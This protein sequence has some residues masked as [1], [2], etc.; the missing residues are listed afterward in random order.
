MGL[1]SD[2][3]NQFV[4]D[5]NGDVYF[6]NSAD[7]VNATQGF[8][9]IRS[10]LTFMNSGD[11]RYIGSNDFLPG[12]DNQV[13]GNRGK[14][15]LEGSFKNPTRDLLRGGKDDDLIFGGIGGQDWI[16]GANDNDT[17]VG[18]TNDSSILRGGKGDDGITGGNKRDL[19]LGAIGKD[20][21][22][23][24]L[25][26]DFFVFRTD[27]T[28]DGFS[29]LVA[30]ASEADQVTDF[31]AADDYV[32]LPGISSHDFVDYVI[33]GANTIVKVTVDGVSQVA[34][35]LNG[36]AAAKNPGITDARVIV[37]SL[38]DKINVDTNNIDAFLNDPFMLDGFG[39]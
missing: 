8:E 24:G 28:G 17:I 12:W 31:N 7:V 19:L 3:V 2:T 4:I 32:I 38:A 23:G 36:I 21:L 29:N 5:D 27:V 35:V 25:G 26:G 14:D 33:D 39:L 37:G 11:D 1:V 13:S 18:G 30:N 20:D 9:S 15:T 10:K 22:T 16:L 34:G 6:S